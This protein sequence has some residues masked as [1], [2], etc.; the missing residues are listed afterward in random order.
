MGVDVGVFVVGGVAVV[1]VFGVFV[2][3]EVWYVDMIVV[4][5]KFLYSV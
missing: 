5:Y 1:G 2:L 4:M 3:F